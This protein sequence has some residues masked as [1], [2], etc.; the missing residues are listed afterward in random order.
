MTMQQIG[1]RTRKMREVISIDFRGAYVP[2]LIVSSLRSPEHPQPSRRY[3][4]SR[5]A[6]RPPSSRRLYRSQPF[7][8]R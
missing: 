7:A 1:F 3:R 2:K 5:G 4:H 8:L 6:S